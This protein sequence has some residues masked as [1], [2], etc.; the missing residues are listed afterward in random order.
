MVVFQLYK[1]TIGDLGGQGSEV[2]AVQGTYKYIWLN[3]VKQHRILK[4][5]RTHM[6]MYV[7]F[8]HSTTYDKKNSETNGNVICADDK[9]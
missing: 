1:N 5:E 8:E 2:K 3:W 4:A 6:Y 9:W 7:E